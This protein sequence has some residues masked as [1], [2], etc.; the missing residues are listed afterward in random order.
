MQGI[1]RLA[2]LVFLFVVARTPAHAQGVTFADLEGATINVTRSELR[3]VR[4]TSG[5][6]RDERAT[7]VNNLQISGGAITGTLTVTIEP[8]TGTGGGSRTYGGK[9]GH[10]LNQPYDFREGK[11]VWVFEGGTLTNLRTQSAGGHLLKIDFSRG[12]GGLTCRVAGGFARENGVGNL[13]TSTGIKGS[14]EFL[15]VKP[16]GGSCR[17][18]K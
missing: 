4:T 12:S 1:V 18:S 7:M 9:A 2:L 6:V 5:V 15:K 8:V 13:S 16:G 17:V 3:T 14:V 11:A 10:K